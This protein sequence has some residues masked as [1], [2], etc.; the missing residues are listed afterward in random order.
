MKKLLLFAFT[1]V[2][3]FCHGQDTT[4]RKQPLFTLYYDPFLGVFNEVVNV[5]I[6]H[7]FNRDISIGF[8]V[9]ASI[10]FSPFYINPLSP[11][12]ANWPG[13]VYSGSAYRLNF[14][15]YDKHHNYRYTAIQ[16]VAKSLWYRN[17]QFYDQPPQ[18]GDDG[19]YY[20]RNED[21]TVWGIDIVRGHEYNLAGNVIILD[22]YYGIGVRNKLR[23]INTWDITNLFAAQLDDIT[24]G[25]SFQN[26]LWPT[27]IIGAR[28]CF[29]F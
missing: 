1:I 20:R 7:R 27:P 23:H 29:N 17:F 24:N 2:T 22:F 3:V 21:E 10:P 5:G 8:D 14:K 4:T 9:A 25:Y 12:Q 18:A 19:T 16:L 26:Q 11:A 15:F 28:L 6:E 13:T